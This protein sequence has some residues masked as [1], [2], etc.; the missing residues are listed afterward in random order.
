MSEETTTTDYRGFIKP[1]F[2]KDPWYGD[3]YALLDQLDGETIPSG[4]LGDRPATAPHGSLWMGWPTGDT[5]RV[6][7]LMYDALGVNDWVHLSGVGTQTNPVETT[8]Y[9]QGLGA[10][11]K[12]VMPVRSTD[13]A[14]PEDGEIWVRE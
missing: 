7:L 8:T 2:R 10:T 1:A 6:Y 14:T 9:Y 5:S 11:D 13:P 4:E 12:L 3:Y